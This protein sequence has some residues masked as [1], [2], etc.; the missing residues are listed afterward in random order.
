[1]SCSQK[2]RLSEEYFDAWKRQ[3]WMR[4]RVA[5]INAGGNPKEIAVGDRQLELAFEECYE[6]WR[7]LNEHSCS[8]ACQQ[9]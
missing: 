4:D 8:A 3:Q 2:A 5:E 6:C 9:I 7:K 1:M